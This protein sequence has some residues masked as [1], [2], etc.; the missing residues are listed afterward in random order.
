MTWQRSGV[1]R[2]V[3]QLEG[4]SSL[5]RHYSGTWPVLFQY[6][7]K[8]R[9]AEVVGRIPGKFGSLSRGPN[10]GRIFLPSFGLVLYTVINDSRWHGNNEEVA[11]RAPSA[12]INLYG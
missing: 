10:P 1:G 7:A 2:P 3:S 4:A 11:P 6:R 5:V 12:R 8:D 9:P